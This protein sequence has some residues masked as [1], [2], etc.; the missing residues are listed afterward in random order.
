M[1]NWGLQSTYFAID[2]E[3]FMNIDLRSCFMTFILLC[4]HSLCHMLPVF[5]VLLYTFVFYH[6][7]SLYV[8]AADD[9][10]NNFNFTLQTSQHS[11]KFSAVNILASY[12]I[13][14]SMHILR[15]LL[16]LFLCCVF[17]GQL[18]YY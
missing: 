2:A 3:R 18:F 10:A 12:S 16:K 1:K 15:I 4:Y 11:D 9:L 7:F 14:F 17:Y 6:Y 5:M 8:L 13:A